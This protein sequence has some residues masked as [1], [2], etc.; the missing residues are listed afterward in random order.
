MKIYAF[1]RCTLSLTAL[2]LCCTVVAFSQRNKKGTSPDNCRL[3]EA[4]RWYEEGR[5]ERI[6]EIEAC[7]KDPKSMSTEKRLEAFELLT[8]SYLY[9]DNIGAAD[10]SFKELLR[11]DPLYQ[12]DSVGESYESYDL[13]YLSNTY[14]RRPIFSMYFGLGGNYTHIEQLQNYGIDNTGGTDDFETYQSRVVFGGNATVGFEL[15]L[16]WGFD[17]TLDATFGY[18]AYSFADSLY[19]SL[20][21]NPTGQSFSSDEVALAN[22]SPLLYST[23]TFREDQFWIDV[24]LTLRYNIEKFH[25]FLPYVYVGGAANFLLHAQLT[26]I[27][28]ANK[29]EITAD[30]SS[31]QSS[32]VNVTK[33]T[34]FLNGQSV[35]MR[36]QVNWSLVAGAGV[37]FRLGRNFLYADFRYT[38]MFLNA[39]DRD[40][41]YANRDLLFTYAHVDNDF[42]M[43]NFALTVGFVKAFY[44]PR[45]KRKHNPLVIGGRYNRFLERERNYI[46]R[47]TDEDLKQELNSAIKEMERMK[48]SLIEDIQK[49]RREGMQVIKDQQRQIEDIKNKRLKVEVKYE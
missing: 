38:R 46:K 24:P 23:L 27:N 41:R 32:D 26:D 5:L 25:G 21:K 43:D 34:N 39:V 14:T 3:D 44:V 36:T 20:S 18:R 19:I 35:S 9:R 16:L 15:P 13:I 6:E 11:I 17:L 28:R 49:G 7:I 2:L 4:K 29:P 10:R 48:P 40:N 12:P 1:A 45:K 31:L 37:K 30:Q 8:E 22:A 42:R 33:T 47:E